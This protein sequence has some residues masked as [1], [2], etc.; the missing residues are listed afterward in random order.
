MSFYMGS[1]TKRSL[2]DTLELLVVVL[3]LCIFIG[4]FIQ[5]LV[6]KDYTRSLWPLIS[7]V[8]T[9]IPFAFERIY[10]ISFPPGL[11]MLVPFGLFMHVAGGIMRWYWELPFFDKVAH[12]ISTVAL[13]LILFSMYLFL[14]YLE[15][16]KK[17]PFF[18]KKIRIFKTQEDDVLAGVAII[19]V[20]FGLA[21]ELAEYGIDL[22]FHTTYNFGLVDSVTDFMGDVIGIL[23][24]LY[25][26]HHAVRAVPPGMH[27]DYL[28]RKR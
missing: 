21:W 28:L 25:I 5:S 17:R 23:L 19:L 22:V 20:I 3:F 12:V 15:Y 14:D 9:L 27:L 16:V 10:D 1:V 6:I 4:L 18:K 8:L 24:V 7:I 11:K 13:G 26:I 2:P